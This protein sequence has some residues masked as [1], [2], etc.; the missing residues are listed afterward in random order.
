M[1]LGILLTL[2][3]YLLMNKLK[4][5]TGK[6]YLNPLFLSIITIILILSFTKID[7]ESYK[8]GADVINLF[9]TPATIALAIPL[10][11]EMK[12]LKKHI[13]AILVGVVVGVITSGAS[14][15]LIK[16]V[17]NLE[18]EH[19]LSFLPKSIT[20]AI[21][22]GLSEAIGGIPSITVFAIIMT[23]IFGSIISNGIFK[24][25]K[26]KNPIA[27]GLALG[28]ASHAIGTSKAA[29]MGDEVAA[30][31]SLAMVASGIVTVIFGMF[32]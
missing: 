3:V 1:I 9:L 21:G 30:A 18:Q 10:R 28:S 19:F 31:S 4:A 32:L 17:F 16:L 7:Y 14:I 27:Q 22:I 11:R 25:F 6:D 2:I 20:T 13:K 8:E 26:I 29:E 23:G 5:K 12:K 15:F 24:L